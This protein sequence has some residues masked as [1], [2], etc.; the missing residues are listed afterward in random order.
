MINNCYAMENLEPKNE[1]ETLA[2][3][4]ILQERT[5]WYI[6]R[7]QRAFPDVIIENE[8]G[9]QLVAEFE[10]KARN[11]RHHG[12][13]TDGCDLV[14]C[15]RNNWP[16]APLPIWA[17]EAGLPAIDPLWLDWERER[18]GSLLSERDGRIETL[19]H[20]VK[21]LC[22]EVE[23]QG[24]ELLQLRLDL[25]KAITPTGT[26]A[27]RDV[28]TLYTADI[29]DHERAWNYFCGLQ[30]ILSSLTPEQTA[31]LDSLEL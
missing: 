24:R 11:F 6:V 19:E 9:A 15:W 8:T 31:A 22:L 4:K 10:Y 27:I 20:E 21:K 7:E 30:E 3:F 17:L 12:H 14:I 25:G 2:L 29:T 5:G 16:D 1:A 26:I 28:A 13:P 23:R 18:I